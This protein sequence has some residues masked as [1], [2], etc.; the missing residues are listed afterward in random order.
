MRRQEKER[1]R[2]RERV[3]VIVTEKKLVKKR[4]FYVESLPTNVGMYLVLLPELGKN[5][6]III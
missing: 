5:K 6:N 3:H 1:G 2:E 4:E